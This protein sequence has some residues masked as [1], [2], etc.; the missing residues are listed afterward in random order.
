MVGSVEMD[1]RN[2]FFEP[3]VTIKMG[4][5]YRFETIDVERVKQ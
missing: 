5:F 3:G 1:I 4:C 2:E